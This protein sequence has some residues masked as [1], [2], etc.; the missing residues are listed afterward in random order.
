MRRNG[1]GKLLF[2]EEREGK[3]PLSIPIISRALQF[4]VQEEKECHWSR[5]IADLTAV[6]ATNLC[7]LL[8]VPSE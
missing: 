8:T 2:S 7:V 4:P 6:S 3:K 5:K 1:E